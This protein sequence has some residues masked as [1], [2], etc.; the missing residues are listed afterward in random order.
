MEIKEIRLS[1]IEDVRDAMWRDKEAIKKKRKLKQYSW[2]QY[3]YE[4]TKIK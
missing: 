2:E 3:F 1:Y 4:K